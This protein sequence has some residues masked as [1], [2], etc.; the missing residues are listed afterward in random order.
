MNKAQK[1][2]TKKELQQEKKILQELKNAYAQAELELCD[3]IKL[4]EADD[5]TQSKIYQAEYQKALKGQISAILDNMNANNYT[6]I[7]DYLK[8]CYEDGYIGTM[9]DLQHQG[10]P[11]IMPINQDQVVKAI[12]LDSQISEGLYSK[13]NINT[14]ELKKAIQHEVARGISNSYPYSEIAR[15]LNSQMGVGLYRASRIART[16]GHRV[17]QTARMDGIKAAKDTGA[18]VVKQWD[19]TLD[20]DTRPSHRKVDGEIRELDEPFSNGLMFPGEPGGK[21][22][23]VINCRCV[24][25]QKARAAIDEEELEE[26]K[27]RAEYFGLDKTK[28]FEEYKNKYLKEVAPLSDDAIAAIGHENS[29]IKTA[30]EKIE[31]IKK[32]L[33]PSSPFYSYYKEEIEKQEKIIEQ[34][35]KTIE[36]IKNGKVIPSIGNNK[37]TK[38][39]PTTVKKSDSVIEKTK[40]AVKKTTEEFKKFEYKDKADKFFREW[41]DRTTYSLGDTEGQKALY[42]YTEGSAFINVPLMGYEG[43]IKR[44]NFKGY[45]KVD[46]NSLSTKGKKSIENLTRLIDN[47]DP[48]DTGVTL[49]RSSS[50]SGL[51]GIFDGAGFDY[52]EIYQ[53]CQDG[54]IK[55]FKG[56][57]VK[58]HAFTSCGIANDAGFGGEVTYTIKCPAGTK[59][60]YAEPQSAAGGT[61]GRK[62]IYTPGLKSKHISWEAEMLI[63]RGTYFRIDEIEWEYDEVVKMNRIKVEM[64]V[65]NQNYN[66]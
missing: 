19:S 4:L 57:V 12:Q 37:K 59:M 56:S 20:G 1:E 39:T 13:M 53:A 38:K 29:L 42:D 18:D 45:G 14:Q 32:T 23:E 41:A 5:M 16:E 64:T 9:Y 43:T 51:A 33:N 46:W 65:I 55:K 54:S 15:N 31:N 34:S 50:T 28:D 27:Q 17:T 47:T 66:D 63:Q 3:K 35:Q 62:K 30:T 8:G 2:L 48:L 49:R 36:E 26:L 44:S 58:N 24:L 22:A 10:V 40:P 21:A 6:T 25:L 52:E 11:L 61:L 7:H 60:V